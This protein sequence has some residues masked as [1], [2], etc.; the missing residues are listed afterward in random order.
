MTNDASA[1]PQTRAE[2]Y[3]RLGLVIDASRIITAGSLLTAHFLDLDLV[4]HQF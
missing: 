1:L 2:R 3:R 4:V